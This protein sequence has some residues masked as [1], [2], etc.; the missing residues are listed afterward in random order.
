[1]R[2]PNELLHSVSTT[3]A[4]AVTCGRHRPTWLERGNRSLGEGPSIGA[5]VGVA[6]LATWFLSGSLPAQRPTSF[7]VPPPVSAAHPALADV[8]L[9]PAFQQADSI[10]IRPGAARAD[11]LTVT[12]PLRVTARTSTAAAPPAPPAPPAPTPSAAPTPAPA[13]TPTPTPEPTPTPS[14]GTTPGASVQDLVRR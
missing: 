14:P 12:R 2:V 3:P 10:Q 7:A 13:S 6:A 11:Q 9:S 1:M 5:G 8:G 4:P